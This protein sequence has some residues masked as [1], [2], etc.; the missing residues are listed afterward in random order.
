MKIGKN[1]INFFVAFDVFPT[2]KQYRD[3]PDQMLLF[4]SISKH[5]FF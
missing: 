1:E 4:K 3:P 5:F 2:R